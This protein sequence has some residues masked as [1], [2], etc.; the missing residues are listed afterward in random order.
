M[1]GIGNMARRFDWLMIDR[2]AEFEGCSVTREFI[3]AG[4]AVFA[5][6]Y[7][8]NEDDTEDNNKDVLCG[9]LGDA[10]IQDEIIKDA[11]LSSAVRDTCPS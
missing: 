7:L 2:C 1:Q 10:M 4:K 3:N 8:R 6:E 11:A 9:D 5:I